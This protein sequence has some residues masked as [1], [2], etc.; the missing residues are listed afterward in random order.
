[1]NLKKRLGDCD[2][3][4]SKNVVI[5]KKLPSSGNWCSSCNGKRLSEK[6][7]SHNKSLKPA[8]SMTSPSVVKKL[9]RELDRVFS[10]YIRQRDADQHGM[11]KCATC[12]A[13]GHWT[14]FDAGHWQ[15]RGSFAIRWNECNVNAQCVPCNRMKDGEY[16]KMGLYIMKTYGIGVFNELIA[17]KNKPHKLERNELQLL[18]TKYSK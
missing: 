12:D 6:K 15:L 1:M 17:L 18:I 2:Q 10:L 16:E 14:T 13:P 8:R 5:A 11:V 7:D 4:P 3:C 9:V